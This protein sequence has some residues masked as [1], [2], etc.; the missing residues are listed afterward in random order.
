MFDIVALCVRCCCG[1]LMFLDVMVVCTGCAS[2]STVPNYKTAPA[3]TKV[4]VIAFSFFCCGFVTVNFCVGLFMISLPVVLPSISGD[5]HAGA[6]HRCGHG[7]LHAVLC[8]ERRLSRGQC[9]A[10]LLS[11]NLVVVVC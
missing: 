11:T 8:F 9:S 3:G 4:T 5:M 6:H 2:R 1:L 7:V 10:L